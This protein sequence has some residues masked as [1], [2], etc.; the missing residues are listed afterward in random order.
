[1]IQIV[2]NC[3]QIVILYSWDIRRAKSFWN[4]LNVPLGMI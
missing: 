4:E 2:N 1:M 3:Y